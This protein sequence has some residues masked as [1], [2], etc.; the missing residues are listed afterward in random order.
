MIDRPWVDVAGQHARLLDV[1][2]LIA[3]LG[4]VGA[5]VLSALRN[6]RALYVMEPLPRPP[7]AATLPTTDGT[8]ATQQATRGEA[9]FKRLRETTS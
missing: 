9:S 8:E 6:T 4:L 5:F 1:G 2:G 3:L 7:I